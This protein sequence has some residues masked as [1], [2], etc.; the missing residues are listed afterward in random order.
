MM[1][2]HASKRK[3]EEGT[4]T[5]V[6]CFFSVLPQQVRHLPI[7]KVPRGVFPMLVHVHQGPAGRKLSP[8]GG[9]VKG[10]QPR[11][12]HLQARHGLACRGESVKWRGVGGRQLRILDPQQHGTGVMGLDLLDKGQGVRGRFSRF[13]L[14]HFGGR[15]VVPRQALAGR[16]GVLLDQEK[17]RLEEGTDRGVVEERHRVVNGL[18][19]LRGARV[20]VC[21]WMGGCAGVWRSCGVLSTGG[22]PI[23]T[24]NVTYIC[25]AQQQAA[26]GRVRILGGV[27]QH[28]DMGEDWVG[29]WVDCGVDA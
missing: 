18:V 25:G 27:Q 28:L 1:K 22:T 6:L 10:L 15:T 19:V 14:H 12:H 7:A 23:V 13:F 2:K 9:L 26:D 3:K 4:G 20:C 21:A 11:R 16:M 17:G 5:Q 24:L 8:L 29:G